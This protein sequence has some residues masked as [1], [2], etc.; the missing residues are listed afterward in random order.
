MVVVLHHGQDLTD[1]RP[2][3]ENAPGPV[4]NQSAMNFCRSRSARIDD[5]FAASNRRLSHG[6]GAIGLD[7]E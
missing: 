5:H 4:M 7:H 2:R 6:S 3:G 1:G